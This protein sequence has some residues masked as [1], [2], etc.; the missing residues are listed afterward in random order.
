MDYMPG[1]FYKNVFFLKTFYIFFLKYERVL[2]LKSY[3]I[4]T[5]FLFFA[6]ISI[7]EKILIVLNFAVMVISLFFYLYNFVCV[8]LL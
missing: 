4:L 5:Y 8:F 6:R 2:N 7:F 1:Q 3:F